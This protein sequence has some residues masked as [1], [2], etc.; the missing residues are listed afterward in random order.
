M[1]FQIRPKLRSKLPQV[2]AALIVG[3]AS[4]AALADELTTPPAP[5]ASQQANVPA[6]GTSMEKV[7]AQFGAPSERIPAVGEPPITRWKYPGFE[8]YFEHQLV[9][10][11]VVSG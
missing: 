3:V 10:H 4:S 7:E 2:L 1:S 5:S 9:I 8:V 11:T 6:R